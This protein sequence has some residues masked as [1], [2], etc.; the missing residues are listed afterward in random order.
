MSYTTYVTTWGNNPFDQIKDM[1]SKN[2]LQPNTRIVLAFASFNFESTSY[3]PGING[4]LTIADIQQI[5]Q[6]NVKLVM[7]Q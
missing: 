4:G 6:L 5:K 1:Y 2:V 3:V 7:K